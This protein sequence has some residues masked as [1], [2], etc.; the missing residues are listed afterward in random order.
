M[1]NYLITIAICL[2]ITWAISFF[3]YDAD[4]VIH[5]LLITALIFIYLRIIQGKNKPIHSFK[6]LT[7]TKAKTI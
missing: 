7:K 6:Q 5:L 3:I 2:V 1:N 4:I